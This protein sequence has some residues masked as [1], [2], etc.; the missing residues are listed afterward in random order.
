MKVFSVVANHSAVRQM[1]VGHVF[2]SIILQLAT[3][4][5]PTQVVLPMSRSV[6]CPM[7]IWPNDRFTCHPSSDVWPFRSLQFEMKEGIALISL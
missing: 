5:S 3:Y 1:S 4:A 2:G 6:G 7:A